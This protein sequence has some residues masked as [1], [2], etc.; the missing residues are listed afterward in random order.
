MKARRLS[1]AVAALLTLGAV[2]V[3]LA[4]D[5]FGAPETADSFFRPGTFF[6]DAS[7]FFGADAS[8]SVLLATVHR[9][10]RSDD[11]FAVYERCGAAPASW[12]R[13]VLT[14]NDGGIAPI[15]LRVAANGTAMAVWSVDAGGTIAYHSAVRPP[16]GA[17]G[18]PQVI[19]S[20]GG[21]GDMRFALSDGGDA[22]VAYTD[23]DGT[24]GTFA[25]LRPAGGSWG[26]AETIASTANRFDVAMSATGA[27][28]VAYMGPSPGYVFARYRPA[29]GSWGA[30]AE[31]MRNAYLNTLDKVQVEFDGAGRT[32]AVADFRELNDTIRYNVGT[33]GA[34]GN[35]EQT[36]DDD[37]V[38]PATQYDLRT[39]EKLVRH[40]NGLVATWT[41]RPTSS[42]PNAEIVVARLN[43]SSWDTKI[44]KVT[45]AVFA[46]RLAVN[47]AGE[48]LLA[49]DYAHNNVDDIHVS[50]A[51][52]LTAPWPDLAPG[53][54]AAVASKQYRDPIAVGGGSA[55]YVGWGVHGGNNQRTEVI[56]TRPA[57]AACAGAPTPTPTPTATASATPSATPSPDPLPATPTPV[58]TP[59]PTP[60]PTPAP[61]G[62]SAIADFTTLPATS[63]CVRGR[64]LT[65]RFRKPPK[66]Y[67]VKS[68]TVKVNRKRVAKVKG[69][70]LKKP[71][72][73]RKLPKRTF[74]VT[75]TI[76]LKKGKGLTEKRR[77]KP[78]R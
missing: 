48:V 75:V 70:K 40:P 1:L 34:W 65:V 16:G 64:K 73:L 35:A 4:A 32:V 25:K 14:D 5:P 68:V 52:S 61:P 39:L 28:V 8:G 19:V 11:Q 36:L 10:A 31:V 51:P 62:P 18:A 7:P 27:A 20:D 22:V 47:A 44:F 37:G 24:P 3:A 6:N 30:A 46:P 53:S 66:G 58:P 59:V 50:I 38:P 78:C 45:G 74:T 60:N 33:N 77:Y 13:T 21:I 17:W 56:S 67:V 76:T 23:G 63:R 43:G 26:A 9:D 12:Q 57:G 55:F 72:Y 49:A 2:P 15:G 71:L 54:P 29:V 42:N 41:R 69:A